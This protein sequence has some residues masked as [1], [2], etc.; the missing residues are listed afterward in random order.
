MKISTH[1]N[2]ADFLT[3]PLDH[4][5]MVKTMQMLNYRYLNTDGEFDD[6]EEYE[7]PEFEPAE[8]NELMALLLALVTPQ[9]ASSVCAVAHTLVLDAPVR[10]CDCAHTR[11]GCA[12]QCL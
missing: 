7:M 8:G 2:V 6:I 3:K 1:D 10:F 11:V 12:C 9:K 5:S 4:Q